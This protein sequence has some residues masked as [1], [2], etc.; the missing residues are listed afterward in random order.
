MV[1]L[2]ASV[3]GGFTRNSWLRPR[4]DQLGSPVTV[5]QSVNEVFG[6]RAE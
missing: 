3:N 2:F 6:F 1:F 5:W 4:A